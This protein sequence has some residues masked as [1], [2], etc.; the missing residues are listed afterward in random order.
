MPFKFGA[1]ALIDLDGRLVLALD[2][3]DMHAIEKI[4]DPAVA[5]Q[6]APLHRPRD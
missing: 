6:K 1:D 4:A 2:G 5:R 3:V